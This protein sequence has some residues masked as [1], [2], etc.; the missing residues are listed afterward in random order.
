MKKDNSNETT[1]V[2]FSL[3]FNSFNREL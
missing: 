1:Q 3:F 2:F